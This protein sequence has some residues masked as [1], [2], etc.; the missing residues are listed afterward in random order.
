MEQARRQVGHTNLTTHGT[1]VS[2]IQ[3]RFQLTDISGPR[4]IS[5]DARSGTRNLGNPPGADHR[6]ALKE[7]SGEQRQVND[8]LPKRGYFYRQCI[9]PIEE[10]LTKFI[11]FHF[12]PQIGATGGD[13]SDIHRDRSARI[14][15]VYPAVLKE[16]QN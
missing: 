10:V 3:H 12:G 11:G 13:H 5:E 9:E 2:P 14:A 15:T 7:D 16:F 6:Q 4:I 1:K 8:T